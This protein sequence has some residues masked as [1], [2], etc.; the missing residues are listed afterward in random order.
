MKKAV[1]LG[2]T[3]WLL[4]GV[5]GC[6]SD[7]RE[8]AIKE[9]IGTMSGAAD[10]VANIK[11]LVAKALADAQKAG[12]P[13]TAADL[14]P[15]E[16]AANTTLRELG[17]KMQGLKLHTEANREG[18]T[19]EQSKEWAQRYQTEVQQAADRLV[20]SQRELDAALQE[21]ERN[22]KDA[23]VELRRTLEEV[24]RE[25]ESVTKQT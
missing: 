4:C 8:R 15:A 19:A 2:G 3:L 24:Q 10:S 13:L 14:K 22:N 7:T 6:S 9:V 20:K 11:T 25:F 5:A 17:K 18:I 1:V 23:V 12:K 16:N 21:A